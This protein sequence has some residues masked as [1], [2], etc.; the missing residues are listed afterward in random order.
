MD[1]SSYQA[2]LLVF[3]SKKQGRCQVLRYLW[4]NA[5][6]ATGMKE[7]SGEISIS[8]SEYTEYKQLFEQLVS[9]KGSDY[10]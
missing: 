1:S 3:F 9:Q 4:E 10:S 2:F 5:S 6:G 8:F 7:S